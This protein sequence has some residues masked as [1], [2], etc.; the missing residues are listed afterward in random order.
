[1]MGTICRRRTTS[2]GRIDRMRYGFAGPHQ[3]RTKRAA[4]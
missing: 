3:E 1:V 2:E 4:F